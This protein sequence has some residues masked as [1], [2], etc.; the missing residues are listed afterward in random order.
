MKS[1]IQLCLKTAWLTTVVALLLMG[2]NLC[3]STDTTCFE[4]GARMIVFMFILS[5][6]TGFL[7]LLVSILFLPESFHAPSQYITVW[8]IMAIGGLLQWFILLPRLFAKRDLT[9]LNFRQA[10]SPLE[11]PPSSS[12]SSSAARRKRFRP[13]SPFDNRGRSPLKRVIT[14]AS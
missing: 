3:V 8:L 12:Q 6:P 10:E 9:I 2:A 13:I 5:F 1:R 11:V 4:A 7:F 14:R